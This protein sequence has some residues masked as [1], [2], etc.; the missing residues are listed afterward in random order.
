MKEA[1]ALEMRDLSVE[2]GVD[3]GQV[4]KPVDRVSISISPGEC[5]GVVGES[6]SG[7]S[8]TA[9]AIVGLLPPVAR[10]I[11][12]HIMLSGVD[13]ARLSNTELRR[14]RGKS[15]GVVFQDPML[16]LNPTMTIF[17][18][19]AEPLLIHDICPRPEV[20]KRVL[21]MLHMVGLP[22]PDERLGDFPHQLS[23]GLRQRVCIA[24]ALICRPSLLIADEPTTALDVTIQRQILE[25]L[26]RLRRQ[27]QMAVM[28]VT[29]NVGVVAQHT[30][31]VAVMYGG[32]IVEHGRT[33]EVLSNPK[34]RYTNAL[35]AAM[36]EVAIANGRRIVSIPGQPPNLMSAGPACR[37]APRCPTPTSQCWIDADV[38]IPEGTTHFHACLNPVRTGEDPT[39]GPPESLRT[40]GLF[41]APAVLHLTEVTRDFRIGR[42]SW[43][44]RG[45]GVLR[46]VAGV[47][48]EV[49]KGEILGLVGES[50]CGKS[51]L[52]RVIAGLD[53]PTSGTVSV[54]PDRSVGPLVARRQRTHLMFQD[55]SSAINPRMLVAEVLDEPFSLQGRRASQSREKTMVSL[56]ESVGLSASVLDRYPHELSGGQRQRLAFARA[57]ATRPEVIVADEPVSALDLSVQAQVLN[58]IKDLQEKDHLTIVFVSHDLA[59]V[60]YMADR[61]SVMY[62]GK[63]VEIGPTEAVYGTPLHPYTRA[64]LDSAPSA[65]SL[66]S[67]S[68]PIE[69]E[70]ASPLNP[71]S[72]CRFH[73]RCPIAQTICREVEPRLVADRP[74]RKVAC[75]FP[76]GP[77]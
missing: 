15:V 59:V 29:H 9:L 14:V 10:I 3:G 61:I 18:Q 7:K 74:F 71:P 54:A 26:D 46:A 24:V 5:V 57:L 25:L 67:K 48:L 53:A 28:L 69:G 22:N 23:G 32:R 42:R 39:S 1:A 34:H 70:L 50:G 52:A 30:D 16:S 13:L 58:L 37:F 63:V 73:P 68:P 11:S 75:H 55:S 60:R 62:L 12:G 47:S 49:H 21:E 51:S 8:T 36:P 31:K 45:Q 65:A 27:L 33:T 38:M 2:I 43:G 76:L 4:I 77:S 41:D 40:E 17:D 64:L 66:T 56:L 35:L 6:G 44:A 20:R 19:V 72:G